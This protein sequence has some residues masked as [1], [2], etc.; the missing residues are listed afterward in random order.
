[1]ATAIGAYATLANV[2]TRMGIADSTD[3]ALLQLFCDRVNMWWETKTERV[4]APVSSA[5]YLFDGEDALENGRLL[6]YPRGIRT[7]TL[8]EVAFYTG[9]AFNTIP[10]TDYFTNPN[11]QELQPGWPATELWMTDVPSSNNPCP[12][13][14]RGLSNIRVTMTSGWPA[15]PDDVAD[16]AE[17]MVVRS[18]QSRKAGERDRVGSVQLGQQTV[19][20]DLWGRALHLAELYSIKTVEII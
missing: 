18:Y 16:V 17:A 2:K 15:I 8:L 19:G 3:D 7:V 10:S 4:L 5:T 13:F 6:L 14:P 20:N 11:P 12:F 1:M 9:A